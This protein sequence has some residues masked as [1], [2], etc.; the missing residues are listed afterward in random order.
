MSFY[1]SNATQLS[2]EYAFDPR[3]GLAV[4]KRWRGTPTAILIQANAAKALGLRFDVR[5]LNEGGHQEITVYYGSAETQDLNTPLADI[6]SLGANEV[7]KNLWDI[8]KV[9]DALL[10]VPID[11]V[12]ELR[13]QFDEVVQGEMEFGEF[14]ASLSPAG[15]SP[16]QITIIQALLRSTQ[17]GVESKPISQGVIRRRLIVPPKT[18]LKPTLTGVDQVIDSANLIAGKDPSTGGPIQQDAILFGIQT[19]YWLKKFPTVEQLS[20]TTWE[21]SQEWWYIGTSFNT[22]VFEEYGT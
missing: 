22:F 19:G 5:E 12:V 8:P 2:D 20:S 21:I 6:W 16:T 15:F 1:G 7:E 10:P 18:N 14:I 9:Y 11:V 13:R 17:I 4:V 3:M